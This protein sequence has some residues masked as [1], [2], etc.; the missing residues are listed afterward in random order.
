[1]D[2]ATYEGLAPGAVSAL[3]ALGRAVAD[4]GLDPQLTE[5]LKVRVS[6]INGC[7][8]CLQ[9]HLNLA[10]KLGVPATKLDLVA[11]W[12]EAGI[13]SARECA[14]LAWAEALT[15]MATRTVED[16]D[17]AALREHFSEPEVAHLTAAI[18]NINAWNRIAG[19]LRFAPPIP[20]LQRAGDAGAK[21][22]AP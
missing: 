6:Q 5:L 17:H 8:F 16:A 7:A 22:P 4:S 12:A 20:P 18:A 14:A 13:H 15:R 11:T 21:L 2:R 1:M 9:Y 3:L 10:R 19:A